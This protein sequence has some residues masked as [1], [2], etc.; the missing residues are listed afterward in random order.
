MTTAPTTCPNCGRKNRIPPAEQGTPRCGACHA[1]LPWVVE[2]GDADFTDIADR[3]STHVLVDLWAPWCGPC[4]QVSP[5]LEEIAAEM[6][7]HLKLVKVNVDAA[8]GVA[9]RFDAYSIPTLVLLKGGREVSR[10]VGAVPKQALREWVGKTIAP[11]SAQ[12]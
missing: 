11:Q 8:R 5:A 1:P 3:A 4:R 10:Q 7:G 9:E 12:G 6:A 2:A